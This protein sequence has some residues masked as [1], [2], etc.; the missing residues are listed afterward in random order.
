MISSRLLF[1][2][3]GIVVYSVHSQGI[4]DRLVRTAIL[5]HNLPIDLDDAVSAGWSNFTQC[6]E[7]LGI[8]FTDSGDSAPSKTHP[9]TLY[10]TAGGQIAGMGM[11]HF[12]T[13]VS[14]LQKYFQPQSNG[15]FRISVSFRPPG[16][17]CNGNMFPELIGTQ[18]VV[19]QGT[20]GWAV[21]LNETAAT[22]ASWTK[23]SCIGGM[24]THWSY[25]L[26][27]APTMSWQSANLFPL[28]TMYNEQAGGI[29][30]A[31]FI[32]TPKLQYAEPVGPWE[33]P[34]PTF[35]MCQNWCDTTCTWDVNFWNTLHFYVDDH[36]LNTCRT[37]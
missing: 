12:G 18:L 23:G 19:D 8:A 17:L 28:V 25:D 13:P 16:D 9:V 22:A 24:G 29:L 34:I 2:L 15:N 35:L 3:L 5:Y 27:S 21:P 1:F 4:G 6:D 20:V 10:F 7:N 33:G 31:F 11:E 26:S 30:S 14:G 37:Y 36:H 32:T